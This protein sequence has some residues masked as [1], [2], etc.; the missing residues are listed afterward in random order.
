MEENGNCI[1]YFYSGRIKTE[2]DYSV[3][4]CVNVR[5]VIKMYVRGRGF[6]VANFVEVGAD[7]FI[8]GLFW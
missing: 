4:L 5:T 3:D 2:R 7:G 1:R 6:V 8:E